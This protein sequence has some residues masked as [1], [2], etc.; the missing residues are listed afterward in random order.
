MSMLCRVMDASMWFPNCWLW[1]ISSY[2]RNLSSLLNV[3]S[4]FEHGRR[5]N[6]LFRYAMFANAKVSQNTIYRVGRVE[7]VKGGTRS[8]CYNQD[9][10]R[11][12]VSA[13]DMVE[14]CLD[15]HGQV[16]HTLDKTVD[17]CTFTV[18]RSFQRVA[19]KARAWAK[20]ESPTPVDTRD[21]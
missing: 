7:A 17:R 10:E 1:S 3:S 2:K 14:E 12:V 6:R 21:P 11:P 18:P 5:V 15:R 8:F 13:V 20:D 4:L 9:W 19:A 16:R